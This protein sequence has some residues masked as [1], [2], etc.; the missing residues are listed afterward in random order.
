MNK[1][2]RPFRC[3][4]LLSPLFILSCVSVGTIFD[5]DNVEKIEEGKTTQNEVIDLLGL[6]L[7]ASDEYNAGKKSSLY[8]YAFADGLGRSNRVVV[9]F[10]EHDIV[11]SLASHLGSQKS[12]E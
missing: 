1:L 6:P 4:I 8:E 12:K 5:V 11:A 9:S 10:D 2:T 7:N 3:I